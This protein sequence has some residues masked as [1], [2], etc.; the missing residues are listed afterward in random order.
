MKKI[1]NLM[2]KLKQKESFKNL[3]KSISFKQGSYSIGLT[4][5]VVAIVV[6]INLI[7]NQLPSSIKTVDV[8]SN[9]V[10]GVSKVSKKFLN[11]LDDKIQITVVAE[12]DS[13]DSR[14]ITFLDKYA[15]LS[16]KISIK[17]VDP[18][19]HPTAL[20]KY[21]TE[22][23]TIVVSSKATGK[24]TIVSLSDILVYSYDSSY[25]YTAS[26]FDGDGQLTS[27]INSVTSED[28]YKIY[29]ATGHGETDLDSSV[30]DLMTKANYS[31]DE[32]NLVMNTTIPDDCDLLLINA[33]TTD[34]SDS[35]A[36]TLSNY[37]SSGGKVL[38]L[39]GTE[40]TAL[41]V[42]DGVLKDYGLQLADGYIADTERS[43]QN[44][45]YYIFPNLT[46]SDD[47]T[48]GISTDMILLVNSRGFTEVDPAD[49]SI[50]LTTLMST[51]SN[52]YAVTDS[53]Q[54][55]G[56]YI[57]GAVA[58]QKVSESGT[59]DS[60]TTDSTTTSSSETSSSD[61]E[62]ANGMFTVIASN[63]LIDSTITSTYTSLENLTL[64]MN[65]ISANF[66]DTG[67]ISI[68]SKS[69]TETNNTVANPGGFS[70]FIIF[71]IPVLVLVIGFVIWL[72]RRKA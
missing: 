17:W 56:T 32:F 63:S 57:L 19:L 28:S 53:A 35:E 25:N 71:G 43:Y 41:P 70:L 61:G 9:Q 42:L 14:I 22:K 20:T 15:G 48:S 34:L 60:S 51:S 21:N 10:L 67:S 58:T 40:D 65:T 33:P 55:Q 37:I 8:S 5:F 16:D 7:A 26:E 3:F 54:T 31:T 69:L 18:V 72:K 27:A 2:D 44:Y 11:K 38:L 23:D 52:G 24:S 49:D 45:P 36:T 12:K 47:Y 62:I 39:L 64:F 50:S 68:K 13:T 59:T 6:V 4:L 30:T 66:G 29:T 1:Q 46:L